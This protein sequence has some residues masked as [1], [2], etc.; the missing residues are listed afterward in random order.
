VRKASYRVFSGRFSTV[1]M[2]VIVFQ[3]RVVTGAPKEPVEG[4]EVA[5]PELH[6][7][8]TSPRRVA[9]FS[10]SVLLV[11]PSFSNRWPR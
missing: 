7:I 5:G 1:A 6:S 4:T 11:T 8:R 3:F 2:A 10:A 9:T